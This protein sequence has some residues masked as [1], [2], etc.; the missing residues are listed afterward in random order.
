MFIKGIFDRRKL[1]ESLKQKQ[2][3]CLD[4]VETDTM[5]L[6]QAFAGATCSN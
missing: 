3:L 5:F 1:V 6:T 2:S 4:T